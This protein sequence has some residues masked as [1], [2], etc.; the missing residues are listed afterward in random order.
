M[1]D[2]DLQPE[3]YWDGGG[4]IQG[5]PGFQR[6]QPG[7][8][9]GLVGEYLP[10]KKEVEVEIVYIELRSTT[11]DVISLRAMPDNG[12]IKY[13][14]VD[15]YEEV[16]ELPFETSVK[17]LTFSDITSMLNEIKY[18]DSLWLERQYRVDID[19]GDDLE[20]ISMQSDF[21]PEL[22]DWNE[23]NFE[24]VRNRIT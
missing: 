6:S 14:L 5:T 19:S 2:W 24:Q 3:T 15:E 10:E 13:R 18:E 11:G 12:G 16:Y 17:P 22:S 4:L 7:L 9:Q 1:F 8:F 23:W 21:Y 20:W